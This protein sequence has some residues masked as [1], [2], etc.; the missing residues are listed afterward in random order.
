[1]M[2]ALTAKSETAARAMG[3]GFC[4]LMIWKSDDNDFLHE[5]GVRRNC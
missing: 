1:M 4:D 5:D 2:T 3:D